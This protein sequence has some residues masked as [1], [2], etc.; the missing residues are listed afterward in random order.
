MKRLLFILSA[1]M[2]LTYADPAA[3]LGPVDASARVGMFSKYVWR[4]MV[5]TDDP[6]LQPEASLGIM[7]FGADVWGNMDL[8]DFHRTEDDPDGLQGQLNEIDYTLRY[9]VSLPLLQL[10]AGLVHYTF[11]NTDADATTEIYASVAANVLFSPSVAIYYDIDEIDGGY[12][13]LGASHALP[14]SPVTDLQLSTSLGYGSADYVQGYFVTGLPEG[15]LTDLDAGP[16]DLQL[17]AELPYHPLP[18]VTLTPSV[19]Y[20]TLLGDADDAAEAGGTDTDAFFLG[21]TAGLSF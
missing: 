2:L 18:M 13:Q 15:T 19:T 20:S 8:T 16:T 12:L 21:L 17:T 11:P 9:D 4:G 5:V 7:G 14:V 10:G 3:A 6:V 1:L